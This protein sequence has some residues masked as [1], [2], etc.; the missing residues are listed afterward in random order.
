[1]G[2]GEDV[3]MD[4]MT[5]SIVVFGVGLLL[6]P[7]L[8]WIGV[9]EARERV[10]RGAVLLDVRSPAEVASASVVGAVA[11]PSG[12][13][14]REVPG[15]AWNKDQEILVFCASGARSAAAVRELKR[16]GYER[17]V[18]LGAFG[19]ARAVAAD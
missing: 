3:A 5:V 10:K 15:C 4:W 19:R 1:L 16:M 18:N 8:R 11:I 2:F 13:L 6:L 7:R 14:S 9:S 12:Q 17:A